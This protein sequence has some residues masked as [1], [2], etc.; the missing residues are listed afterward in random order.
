MD[1]P[2]RTARQVADWSDSLLADHC[3]LE[4]WSGDLVVL[5]EHSESGKVYWSRFPIPGEEEPGWAP[6]VFPQSPVEPSDACA[7][8]VGCPAW[9]AALRLLR[10]ALSSS[11]H[12]EEQKAAVASLL[13]M[14]AAE[15]PLE[16]R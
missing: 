8:P 1:A 14:A 13:R 3:W 4:N 12:P 9:A 16:A 6:F 2:L 10:V 7:T 11:T 15:R 5:C